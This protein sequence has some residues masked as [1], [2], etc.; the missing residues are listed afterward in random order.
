MAIR[1]WSSAAIV[2]ALLLPAGTAA[3]SATP[4]FEPSLDARVALPDGRLQHIVCTGPEVT[5][6]PVVLFEADLGRSAGTWAAVQTSLPEDVRACAHDRPGTGS[7]D[8]GA[9]PVTVDGDVADLHALLAAA[10]IPAPYVLVADGAGAW[11]A[12]AFADA[13]PD[14]VAGA[15]FSD[16]VSPTRDGALRALLGEPVEGEPAAVTLAR[17]SLDA[18]LS[19]PDATPGGVDLRELSARAISLDLGD[20]PLVLLE[21]A[22]PAGLLSAGESPL[23]REPRGVPDRWRATW[24]RIRTWGLTRSSVVTHRWVPGSAGIAGRLPEAVVD[25]IADVHARVGI[26]RGPGLAIAR[27]QKRYDEARRTRFLLAVEDRS[28][29]MV[30]MRS[31]LDAELPQL[32]GPSADTPVVRVLGADRRRL[33]ITWL[34]HDARCEPEARLAVSARPLRVTI[35]LSRARACAG[36]PRLKR[37]AVL[38][39]RAP[40]PDAEPT[41]AIHRGLVSWIGSGPRRVTVDIPGPD[42]PTTVDQVEVEDLAGEIV[43]ARA[44]PVTS[45]KVVWIGD[46]DG[47]QTGEK[48]DELYVR[49]ATLPCVSWSRVTLRADGTVTVQDGAVPVCDASSAPR[50][51]AIRFGRQVRVPAPGV[52]LATDPGTTPVPDGVLIRQQAEAAAMALSLVAYQPAGARLAQARDL[53]GR[54]SPPDRWVWAIALRSPAGNDV[55]PDGTVVDGLPCPNLSATTTYLDAASGEPLL[56]VPGGF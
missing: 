46:P 39:L 32:Q 35:D 25:A 4:S 24:D 21:P 54:L 20:R 44:A 53:D 27:L 31:A 51:V 28:G 36:P 45:P 6:H 49:W 9:V 50:T 15:V 52:R 26:E 7:S 47:V 13:Y 56:I 16:V 30:R 12:A 55:C 17:G 14:E 1:F 2:A 41:V 23:A 11:F 10:S 38:L 42:D 8:R 3:Q 18:F 43:S 33:G 40:L 48:G 29:L 34:G 5:P 22:R 19:P 37:T